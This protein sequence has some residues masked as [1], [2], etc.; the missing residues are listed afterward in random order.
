MKP[1]RRTVVFTIMATGAITAHLAAQGGPD[2]QLPKG[3]PGQIQESLD[4]AKKAL[5]QMPK[6]QQQLDQLELF[7]LDS[8][9]WR[10]DLGHL[11]GELDRVNGMLDNL[12]LDQLDFNIDGALA[13][14]W[15]KLGQLQPGLAFLAYQDSDRKREALDRAR[16]AQDRAREAADRARESV[17]RARES[18]QQGQH[19][20]DDRQYDRAV[21][22][23]DRLIEVK[24]PSADGAYYWK[25]YA[26]NKLGKRDEALA[27]LAEIPKQFPQSRWITDAN[28]LK[29][30]IQGTSPESQSDEELKLYA[31]GALINSDPDRAIPLLEK[32]LNEPK[33]SLSIKKRALYVLAQS[34]SDKAR[35][36]VGQYAKSGT[37]PDLQ[38]SAVEYLGTYRS[39]DSRQILA[40]VYAAVNDV[41]V[42]RAVLR[43]FMISHDNEHLFNAAKSESNA[44]LRRDAIHWLGTMQ[45]QSE[46]A[47][48]YST[49][50]NAELKD[51]IIQAIFVGG[52]SDKLIEIAKGEK[53]AHLRATAIS[54]LGNMRKERTADALASM[55]ASE[56]DKTIKSQII[57]SLG[58]QQA[59]KQLV[60]VTRG[61]KD[62]ELKKEGVQRLSMMRSKE[63]TDY[64]MEL[65]S[66]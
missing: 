29:V 28:A 47:Q 13:G 32:L 52:G 21:R 25:A 42:K 2:P 60:D 23:F 50:T 51:S 12:K 63:A 39:R 40:D 22:N 3:W 8:P 4:A 30:E 54:R 16:E 46:L 55:Y 14:V 6:L 10:F 34:R 66:K 43:G 56:S 59:A 65:L 26:L 1:F 38:L 15:G 41:N 37:N 64:L 19:A 62:A 31:I 33:N 48:L 5:G 11:D 24:A 20:I 18:Y 58:N 27:A 9:Q 35:D 17:D 44:D 61:E 45:A 53:D 7:R 49:E 36:I 57:H